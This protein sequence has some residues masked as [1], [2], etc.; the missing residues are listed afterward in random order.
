MDDFYFKDSVKND[1]SNNYACLLSF[2]ALYCLPET[3]NCYQKKYPYKKYEDFYFS[4]LDLFSKVPTE[5]DHIIK[6]KKA[7]SNF[8]KSLEDFKFVANDFYDRIIL[9][10]TGTKESIIQ[11]I[12]VLCMIPFIVACITSFGYKFYSLAAIFFFLTSLF[13]MFFSIATSKRKI[14]LG[15]EKNPKRQILFFP[16]KIKFVFYQLDLLLNVLKLNEKQEIIESNDIQ[17][18]EELVQEGQLEKKNGKYYLL[19]PI[20]VF[21]K[22]LEDNSL[23]KIENKLICKK[24]LQKNGSKIKTNT[25][26]S[27]KSRNKDEKK[28]YLD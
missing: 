15:K 6:R 4:N 14:L 7:D 1:L 9:N 28:E 23:V 10:K 17:I 22:W 27:A 25:I 16:G 26:Y 21:L 12:S 24:I 5:F 11:V 8:A 3:I 13:F 2:L 19:G 18:L 20:K